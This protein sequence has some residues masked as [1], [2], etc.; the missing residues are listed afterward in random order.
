[1][2]AEQLYNTAIEGI[3]KVEEIFCDFY[4]EDRV[5]MQYSITREGLQ[6]WLRN[7]PLESL[8]NCI[9]GALYV[10][11][12]HVRVENENGRFVDI[13]HLY[14][15]L[16]IGSNGTLIGTFGLNRAEYPTTHI[17]SDYMHS[18]VS[19][20]PDDVTRFLAPCM[21]SGPIKRTTASLNIEFSEDLWNL[22]C[23]ELD[24]Y[25]Q[26]ESISGVPYRRLENIGVSSNSVRTTSD[27]NVVTNYVYEIPFIAII[28]DFIL[29]FVK[30]KR[31]KFNYK[32]SSYSI[33]MSFKEYM[34]LVS[35]EFID[36]YNA[37]SG[38]ER[39]LPTYSDLLGSNI[40]KEVIIKEEEFFLAD[41]GR[42][43]KHRN[44]GGLTICN[45]K[46]NPVNIR[47]INDIDYKSRNI[48]IILN[49]NIAL[50]ILTNI[51]SIVNY[52]YGKQESRTGG[53][54]RYI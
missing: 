46:G 23:L 27:Y 52:R 13:N 5:D 39:D 18:H 14:A 22:F 54:I 37:R 26:T 28:R 29:H 17:N 15:R 2:N 41:P 11:F 53:Q 31:L 1:M 25:V 43:Y 44:I 40:L 4:G 48:S 12:P 32:N 38:S 7:N 34:L 3:Q 42:G 49:P 21:G 20:I 33:A 36:W 45:F 35:N 24:K 10:H 6:D 16:L 47:I 9:K 19:G 50:H 8:T 51:L 30:E